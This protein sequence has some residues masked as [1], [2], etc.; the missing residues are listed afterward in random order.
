MIIGLHGKA[1]S[2]KDQFGEYLITSFSHKG[3]CFEHMAF[4]TQ[5]K[6]MCKEHFGLTDDQLWERGKNMREAPDFRFAKRYNGA[7]SDPE[8]YWSPR[9]IM[10]ELGSFYRRIKHDYWVYALDK[11]VKKREYKDVVITDVRHV[12]EC[13]YVRK[14][15]GILIKITR[16]VIHEIRGMNHESETALN[17]YTA[18]DIIINNDGTLE[19]LYRAAEDTVEAIIL[20]EQLMT[21]GEVYH[22]E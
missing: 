8:N 19:D 6:N 14:N 4:A 13:D 5:L 22:G 1:R 17:D 7:S 11:E 9:E 18:F 12:N 15:R 3:R 2:G 21:K 20:L 10:Q 16:P